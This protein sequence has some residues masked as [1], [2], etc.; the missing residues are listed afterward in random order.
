MTVIKCGVNDAGDIGASCGG[1]KV[2]MGT[3]KLS[4][5]II[6]RFGE[7]RNLTGKG[8]VFIKDEAK[9]AGEWV[10]TLDLE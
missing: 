6:A 4:D 7:G 2:R 1:I 10:H 3:A 5:M 8:K 9:V